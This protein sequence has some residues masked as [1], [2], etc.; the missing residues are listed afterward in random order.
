[1][2]GMHQQGGYTQEGLVGQVEDEGL[3]N[4]R[5]TGNDWRG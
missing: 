2:G 4:Q 3:C 1:M 5:R